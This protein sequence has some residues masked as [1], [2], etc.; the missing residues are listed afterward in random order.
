MEHSDKITG[1]R[2]SLQQPA[3]A[4]HDIS[5]DTGKQ[6]RPRRRVWPWLLAAGL[7]AL[8]LFAVVRGVR[9]SKADAASKVEAPQ[10]ATIKTATARLGPIGYYVRALGT[11]TPLATVNLY[12]Q[13][14]GRVTAVHYVEGQLVHRGDPLIEVDSRPYEAQLKEAQG[15]LQH[16]RGVLA[17]AEMDLARYKDA[18][19]QQ[20]ISRQTYEDQISLVEQYRGTVQ[21]DM[22]QVEYAQVQLSY[23]HLTSPIDGRVGLRL[24]DPGNVIFS[25]GSNPLVVI[26]QLQPITVVFNVAED[27]LNQVRDQILHRTSLPVDIFDRTQLTQLAT[28]KLLT[29]DNQIDTTTG[30]VRF[31]GQF[32]NSDLRLYPNQFVNARLLVKTLE[33]AT[34]VPTAAVQRN[35]TQAFVYIVSG[36]TVT[37]RNVEELTNENQIAAVTGINP[38]E[39]VPITGFDKLQEGSKV[40][41]EGSATGPATSTASNGKMESG[42]SGSSR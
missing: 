40:I 21:N 26:T 5:G 37:L 18:S 20:A 28:G 36:D 12:S 30:T 17:Q 13:I 27:D 35:G 4:Q 6:L 23:C 16:D 19:A 34:L 11:V 29:L 2:D 7:A 33:N 3:P 10:V 24:V 41:V 32:P 39:V 1:D 8:V 22:G 15:T 9:K 31:R 25:G 42:P 38:G 14:T